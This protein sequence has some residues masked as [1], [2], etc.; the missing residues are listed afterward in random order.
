VNNEQEK[1]A[2]AFLKSAPEAR[3]LL[4]QVFRREKPY[5]DVK[6][7]F[8]RACRR[9]GIVDFRFHDLRHYSEFRIMP[10]A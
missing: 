3:E 6:N 4:A 10:S 9:A 7:S 1:R 2:E 5:Q 8:V